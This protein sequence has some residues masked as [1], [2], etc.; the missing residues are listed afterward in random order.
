[1]R[2]ALIGAGP[3]NLAILGRLLFTIDPKIEVV[4]DLFDPSTI[5]GRV[6]DPFLKNNHTFL[7]NTYANQVTLFDDYE[8]LDHE[9][10]IARPNLL[11]WA[12]T[13]AFDYLSDHPEYP[14]AYRDEVLSLISANTFSSRGL[15]GVYAA[16][17]FEELQAACPKNVSIAF[18][19]KEVVDLHKGTRRFKL[20]TAD[21]RTARYDRVVLAP[22]HIDNQLNEKQSDLMDFAKNKG[23]VYFPASHPAENDFTKIKGDDSVLIE[24]LGLS[25][26]DVLLS[27]TA[28]KG[29]TFITNRDGSL[30]YRPSGRE[31]KI[32]A[33]S[34]NGLP[35]RSKGVNQKEASQLYQPRFFTLPHLKE[36]ALENDRTL[37][38]DT[39][40]TILKQ[41]LTYKFLFNQIQ[42]TDLPFDSSKTNIIHFIQNPK[43]WP[44]LNKVFDLN[45]ETDINW[46]D[47]IFP[48]LKWTHENYRQNLENHL[49]N[50]IISAQLGNDWSPLTGSYDLLRDLRDIVRT[51]YN[52]GYFT[53]DGYA[54]MLTA[55]R[56]FDNQLSAGPPIIRMRQLLALIQAGI[57]TIAGPGYKTGHNDQRFTATDNFGDHYEGT[58]LIEARL[59]TIDFRIAKSPLIR[60]L[61][62]QGLIQS[63]NEIPNGHSSSLL[64]HTIKI[65][66]KNFMAIDKRNQNVFGLFISGI[67]LEG[68]R[69]FNTVIPRPYVNTLIF[70]ESK[71]LVAAL[72]TKHPHLH[73]LFK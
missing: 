50:D 11:T 53:D 32:V 18:H 41:E 39:F 4:I 33:G 24:G 3:R 1:M 66:P 60:S 62:K 37:P 42:Q 22:G 38:F 72:L 31:P 16:W 45:I 36:V 19:Q 14:S 10:P 52:D 8:L 47:K 54:K 64:A 35:P 63:N 69:W 44:L 7:M 51:L 46:D 27:L 21:G 73:E 23:L 40:M 30:T 17:Y 57:I 28:G 15:F 61:A 65:N 58:C 5:G 67:P 56:Y 48:A 13:V 68:E 34:F 43:H 12:Q 25:F 70:K 29:G 71:E 49:E 6:W 55:F 2:I 9:V 59:S 20:K 26:F